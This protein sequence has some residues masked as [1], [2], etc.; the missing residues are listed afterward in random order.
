[1]PPNPS[2]GDIVAN[3][4]PSQVANAYANLVQV[5]NFND[6][7]IPHGANDATKLAAKQIIHMAEGW[8]FLSS[9]MHAFLNHAEGQAIHFAYYAE[10]RAAMSLFAGSSIDIQYPYHKYIDSSAGNI[11]FDWRPTHKIVW[12][13]WHEWIKSPQANNILNNRII[14]ISPNITIGTVLAHTSGMMTTNILADWGF[15]LFQLH[16]DHNERNNRS[17]EA[18]WM[19]KALTKMSSEDIEYFKSLWDLLLPSDTGQGFKLD[20]ALTHYLLTLSQR[21]EKKVDKLKAKSMRQDIAETIIHANGI[22]RSV[23]ENIIV[24]NRADLRLFKYASKQEQNCLNIISRAILLLRFSL[25]SVEMNL[26]THDKGKAWLHKWLEHA[27]IWEPTE[28]PNINDIQ[29]DYENALNDFQPINIPFD[30]WKPTNI[31]S[32]RPPASYLGSTEA[33]LAWGFQ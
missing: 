18:Y 27:G 21:S 31:F 17:Y 30:I 7:I 22:D 25:L 12:E 15:D 2:A 8:R 3:A 5:T 10:L 9:A 29:T 1:M 32:N 19:D 33:C 13:I 11:S 4:D 28:V 16:D 24:N 14:L 26:Q 6:L 20:K 23:V